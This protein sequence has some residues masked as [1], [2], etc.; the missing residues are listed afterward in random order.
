M[1]IL[2]E[3]SDDDKRKRYDRFSTIKLA[4][5]TILL[6]CPILLVFNSEIS[7]LKPSSVA[8][9]PG[10]CLKQ[11]SYLLYLTPCKNNLLL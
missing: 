5:I 2:P 1:T 11:V 8:V 9:Q 6:Y 4:N 3:T 10:L 7:N